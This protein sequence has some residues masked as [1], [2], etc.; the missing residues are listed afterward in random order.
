MACEYC[1]EQDISR[2]GMRSKLVN[3]K[4]KTVEICASCLGKKL[5]WI[6]PENGKLISRE[7]QLGRETFKHK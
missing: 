1:S 4:V 5:R 7:N 2:L 6:K 3:G